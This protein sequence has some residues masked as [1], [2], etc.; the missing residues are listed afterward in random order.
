MK[1]S[2]LLIPMVM[3]GVIFFFIGFSMGINSYLIP[4]LRSAFEL[5]TMQSY[6]ILAFVYMAFVLFG[7]PSGM[8]ISKIGYRKSMIGSF[9]IFAIGFLL[10]I[11]SAIY[12]SFLFFLTASFICGMGNTLLQASVNPYITIVGPIESA[13]KRICIMGILN[14]LAWAVAPVFLSL[15]LHL[16]QIQLTDIYFPF[17][18]ISIGFVILGI[19]MFYVNMPEIEIED[20]IL[21]TGSDSDP[22]WKRIANY[23][24]LLLGVIA[25]F[26]YSGVEAITLASIVDFAENTGLENPEKYAS[27]PVITMIVGYLFGIALIP[28]YVSQVRALQIC[29]GLGL[30]F[31]LCIV[32]S[33]LPL[34]IYFV[35][36]LG[37]SNAIMWP[38]IWPLAMADLGAFT[39]KG[40]SLLVMGIVGGAVF[41]LLFGKI[42]D[43]NMADN[44]PNLHLAYWICLPLYLYIFYFAYKGYK[45]RRI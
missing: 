18:L 6:L 34:T 19:C 44:M 8:I 35:A 29:A 16:D 38:A 4:Y 7:Y 42:A 21:N 3:I 40:A 45:K 39:Q 13:A 36:M 30:I 2:K 9:F 11:P 27:Y 5:S 33:P 20:N 32:L 26:F 12:Q 31:S 24:H 41:P 17:I 28:N 15:F 10:F 25:L 23:P 37:L 1:R 43:I 14:K 22:F